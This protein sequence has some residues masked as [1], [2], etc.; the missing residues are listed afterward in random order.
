[1]SFGGGGGSAGSYSAVP[2]PPPKAAAPTT[3]APRKRRPSPEGADPGAG[4]ERSNQNNLAAEIGTPEE[5]NNNPA[6]GTLI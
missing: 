3:A 1:M 4:E 2:P 6:G 5:G